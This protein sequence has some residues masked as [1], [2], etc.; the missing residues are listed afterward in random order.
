MTLLASLT[1]PARF[2]AKSEMPRVN[3]DD[4]GGR[5][6]CFLLALLGGLRE[7]VLLAKVKSALE[8]GCD[9]SSPHESSPSMA[10]NAHFRH[11]EPCPSAVSLG[12]LGCVV[13]RVVK[14]GSKSKQ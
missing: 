3:A 14:T 11:G 2:R 5:T 8:D 1:S 13:V 6:A 10:S 7:D 9:P 4:L 12:P